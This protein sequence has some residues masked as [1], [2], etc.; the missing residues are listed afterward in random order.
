MLGYTRHVMID[1]GGSY[2]AALIRPGTD[3]DC[4]FKAFDTDNQEWLRVSGWLADDI[5]DAEPAPMAQAIL[6]TGPL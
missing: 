4:S 3:L 1:I 5:S 6:S 2:F